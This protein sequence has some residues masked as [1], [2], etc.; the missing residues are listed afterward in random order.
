MPGLETMKIATGT[1]RRMARPR[2]LAARAAMALLAAECQ[3]RT[4]ETASRTQIAIMA[5]G[6]AMRAYPDQS[7]K[8]LPL[9]WP[10]SQVSDAAKRA[11]DQVQTTGRHHC[12]R[13]P[14]SAA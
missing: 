1:A 2:S 10:E 6:K 11:A 5:S 7:R 8:S 9:E 4:R 14:R 13:K 3:L 12:A